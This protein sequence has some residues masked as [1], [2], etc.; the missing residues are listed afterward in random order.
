MGVLS[1]L[2]F[3]L[4][5]IPIHPVHPATFFLMEDIAGII[6]VI[7]AEITITIKEDTIFTEEATIITGV[8]EEAFTDN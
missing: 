1:I 7:L 2:T 4:T 3:P 5:V 6:G 8:T